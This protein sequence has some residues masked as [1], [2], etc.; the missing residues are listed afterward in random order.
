MKQSPDPGT[1]PLPAIKNYL[2]YRSY[3][4][5]C[6]Q[7]S[8]E[9]G[10]KVTNRSFA[11]AI[12]ITSSS[13]LTSVLQGEKGIRVKT[14]T[15]ISQF[16]NHNSWEERFF[17]AL[18]LFNQAQSIEKRNNYFAQLKSLLT[19]KGYSASKI[20]HTDQYEFYSKWYYS[21]VRSILGMKKLGDEYETIAR[22]VTPSI[23]T[24]QAKK[25]VKL[26]KKLSFIRENKEGYYELTDNAISTG[27]EVRSLAVA[28]F[29]RETMSLA[30]EALERFPSH[31]RDISSLSVGISRSSFEKI[32]AVLTECRKQVIEIA[33]NDEDANQVFQLNLQLYPLSRTLNEE[34]QQS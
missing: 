1:L 16:L 5:D 26:L 9:C 4:K 28:N 31:S 7:C 23:T 8:K 3:L 20:L 24:R 14:A 13:W 18:V 12:G 19:H 29:Q 11:Q 25:S 30:M 6:L 21:A 33:N 27:L 17:M 15:A 32:R 2:D 22:L 10:R 34:D